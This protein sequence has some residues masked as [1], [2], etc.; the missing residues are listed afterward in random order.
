M[1]GSLNRDWTWGRLSTY[2]EEN[3]API[4]YDW[5]QWN[6]PNAIQ[7]CILIIV[8]SALNRTVTPTSTNVTSLEDCLCN[9]TMQVHNF[10][11]KRMPLPLFLMPLFLLPMDCVGCRLHI[12]KKILFICFICLWKKTTKYECKIELGSQLP[13]PSFML[14][15]MCWISGQIISGTCPKDNLMRLQMKWMLRKTERGSGGG[16]EGGG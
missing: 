3:E 1:V 16:N 2:N 12:F 6:I 4:G 15:Y 13:H 5:S 7:K 8:Q 9:C 14:T 11:I 10:T